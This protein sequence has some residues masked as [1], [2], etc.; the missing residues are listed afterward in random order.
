MTACQV[1]FRV[2][3]IFQVIIT[4][5][6]ITLCIVSVAFLIFLAFFSP[7]SSHFGYQHV[8][9]KNASESMRKTRKKINNVSPTRKIFSILHYALGKNGSLL[10][11]FCILLRFDNKPYQ[12]ATPT[13][14][15]VWA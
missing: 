5:G 11:F 7:F 1:Y 15:V 10:R 3:H 9:I 6:L 13:C 14:S 8:G 2:V 12:N 4:K